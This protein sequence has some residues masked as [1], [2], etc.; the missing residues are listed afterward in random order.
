M[1]AGERVLY[2]HGTVAPVSW[3]TKWLYDAGA[4]TED[5]CAPTDSVSQNSTVIVMERIPL[6]T[7]FTMGRG[8]NAFQRAYEAMRHA[9]NSGT[10]RQHLMT[11][12]PAPPAPSQPPPPG[13]GAPVSINTVLKPTGQ[14]RAKL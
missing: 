1:E 8:V 14:C 6:V 4:G 2:H 9:L 10:P 11:L 7:P 12:A 5:E 13:P 3:A